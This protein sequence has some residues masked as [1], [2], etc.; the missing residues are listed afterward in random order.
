MKQRIFPIVAIFVII[1]SAFGAINLATRPEPTAQEIMAQNPRYTFMIQCELLNV[2][3]IVQTW[4]LEDN[5][6]PKNG[7]TPRKYSVLCQLNSPSDITP[8]SDQIQNTIPVPAVGSAHTFTVVQHTVLTMLDFGNNQLRV[9]YPVDSKGLKIYTLPMFNWATQYKVTLYC[10]EESNTSS[11]N[12][13]HV[14][15]LW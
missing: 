2:T 12:P 5:G 13:E 6:A 11:G 14:C 4:N 15:T 7:K 1:L 10:W 9:E 3:P 8:L